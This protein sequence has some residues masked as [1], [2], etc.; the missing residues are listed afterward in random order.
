MPP[1]EYVVAYEPYR[2][3]MALPEILIVAVILGYGL[4]RH[5]SH[6]LARQQRGLPADPRGLIGLFLAFMVALAVTS[7]VPTPA[8]LV[9]GGANQRVEGKVEDMRLDLTGAVPKLDFKV[10][11]VN[12][13]VESSGVREELFHLPAEVGPLREGLPVR[14]GLRAG[15]IVKLEIRKDKEA[16][17]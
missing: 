8:W 1:A 10:S 14:V 16:N 6:M 11:G 4:V 17:P 2:F 12:I 7:R 13:H 5:R 15:V 3:W 9:L